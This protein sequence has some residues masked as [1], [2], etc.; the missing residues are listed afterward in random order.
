MKFESCTASW[1]RRLYGVI[2]NRVDSPPWE[3]VPEALKWIPC[4]FDDNPELD[5][6][7]DAIETILGL[8]KDVAFKDI[9]YLGWVI[10]DDKAGQEIFLWPMSPQR[11]Q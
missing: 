11:V 4:P 3:A 9:P 5:S 2:C 7:P 10:G 6:F 8:E 1:D